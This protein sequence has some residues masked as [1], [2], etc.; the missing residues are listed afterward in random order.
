MKNEQKNNARV[1]AKESKGFTNLRVE[2]QLNNGQKV[3][4]EIKLN[5]ISKKGLSKL[6]YKI[7]HNI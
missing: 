2:I 1:Y 3:D 5:P 4:C 7:A 6:Y